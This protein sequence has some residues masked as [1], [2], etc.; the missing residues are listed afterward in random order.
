[1]RVG[2][3]LLLGVSPAS[4]SSP[5]SF[6]FLRRFLSAGRRVARPRGALG[7][8][9]ASRWETCLGCPAGSFPTNDRRAIPTMTGASHTPGRKSGHEGR[10]NRNGCQF[11]ISC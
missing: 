2:R 9:S 5:R 7:S 4:N 6:R 8:S 11:G 1:M 3:I 10:R